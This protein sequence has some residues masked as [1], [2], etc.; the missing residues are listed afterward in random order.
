MLYS[1]FLNGEDEET[2]R[3]VLLLILTQ[4]PRVRCP[5]RLTPSVKSW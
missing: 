1:A 2:G 3:K 5:P 4:L